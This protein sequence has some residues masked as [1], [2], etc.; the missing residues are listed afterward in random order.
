[1][2]PN[3]I[4]IGGHELS[5]NP[6]DE[7]F[8]EHIKDGKQLAQYAQHLHVINYDKC[9][10]KEIQ[11]SC[12]AHEILHAFSWMSGLNELFTHKRVNEEIVCSLFEHFLWRF[13][14]DNTNFFELKEIK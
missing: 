14:K 11:E 6:R 1:M 10:P 8:F 5:L 4:N 7:S 2:I 3:K 12:V 9:V 13:L